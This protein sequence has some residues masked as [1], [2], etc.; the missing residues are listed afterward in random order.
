MHKS[1][2]YSSTK[3]EKI[4]NIFITWSQNTGIQGYPRIFQDE[5]QFSVRFIWLFVFIIFSCITSLLC[6]QSIMGYIQYETVSTIEI[7]RQ[8][9]TKFPTITIC[10]SNPFTS[11]TAQ[12][13][14]ETLAFQKFKINITNMKNAQFNIYKENLTN[15]AKLFVNNEAFGDEKRKQL[16][17]SNISS[18]VLQKKINMQSI[19][20]I[21]FDSYFTWFWHA[22]FGNCYQFNKVILNSTGNQSV[23]VYKTDEQIGEGDYFGLQLRYIYA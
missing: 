5:V 12:T 2:E 11:K 21:D 4:K 3:K 17:F 20:D 15:Y 6:L 13:L 1:P 19:R 23:K 8:V 18:L 7:I 14:L 9:P 10:D 16:G 22:N